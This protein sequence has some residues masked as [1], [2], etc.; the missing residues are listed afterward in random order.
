VLITLFDNQCFF[1]Q[2]VDNP[3]ESGYAQY[4]CPI[5]GHDFSSADTLQARRDVISYG[6]ADE[7]SKNGMTHV[8]NH[9]SGVDRKVEWEYLFLDCM[10]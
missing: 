1:P 3:S 4:A 5:C 6:D 10:L 8:T 7:L 2:R 9:S